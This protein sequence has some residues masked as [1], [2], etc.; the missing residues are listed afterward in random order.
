MRA[1]I[2]FE[3]FFPFA[4]RLAFMSKFKSEIKIRKFLCRKMTVKGTIENRDEAFRCGCC[5]Q[6][7]RRTNVVRHQTSRDDVTTL[8]PFS[9]DSSNG[10]LTIASIRIRSPAKS[11][12]EVVYKKKKMERSSGWVFFPR[13]DYTMPSRR[14]LFKYR[15]AN[16]PVIF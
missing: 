7:S 4:S 12:S 13:D 2:S 15:R 6:Q 10:F 8:C 14:L 3:F 16:Y 11:W 9:K 5:L 1:R